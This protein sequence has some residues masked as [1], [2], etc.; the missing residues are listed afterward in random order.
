MLAA[1]PLAIPSLITHIVLAS[2]F[3]L[4]NLLCTLFKHQLYTWPWFIY[5]TLSYIHDLELYTWRWV[6]YMTLSYIHDLELYTWRW[7]IY[8]TLSYIHA[9][10]LYTWPWII[11]M[12][13]SYIHDLELYTLPPCIVDIKISDRVIRENSQHIKIQP[14]HLHDTRVNCSIGISDWVPSWWIWTNKLN[15]FIK[16][17]I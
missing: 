17:S 4:H 10:E 5:M 14:L 13:L 16:S 12:T 2:R 9:L 11:Y 6:I 8:M 15:V 7:V 3:F 1:W